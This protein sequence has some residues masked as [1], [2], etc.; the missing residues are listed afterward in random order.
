MT[1]KVVRTLYR[2]LYRL[3]TRFDKNPS[4]KYLIY[5]NVL[6]SDATHSNAESVYYAQLLDT[7]F[8]KSLFMTPFHIGI[9]LRQLLHKEF[10][11][12]SATVSISSRIDAG[13]AAFRKLSAVWRAYQSISAASVDEMTSK[14]P[15][16]AVKI[17]DKIERGVLLCAHP[18]LYGIFSRSVVLIIDHNEKGTYGLILN[19][20]TDMSLENGTRN[21]PRDFLDVFGKH[22]L[23]FGGPLPRLQFI[24]TVSD[25]RGVA[26]PH[27]S[28]NHFVGGGYKK[29]MAAM[30][31]DCAVPHPVIFAGY[32]SWS[33]GQLD[34][35]LQEG[36]WTPVVTDASPLIS[37]MESRAIVPESPKED[38]DFGDSEDSDDSEEGNDMGSSDSEADSDEDDDNQ[39]Y[40]ESMVPVVHEDSAGMWSY[41]MS[42]IATGFSAR[43]HPRDVN[44]WT[45]ESVDWPTL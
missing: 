23:H 19:K 29:V 5:R 28:R 1:S 44:A 21:I 30:Q 39:H 31:G 18:M 10:R 6:P 25:C 34:R 35:E 42:K 45:I 38:L 24:H 41:L 40:D 7:M 37:H 43:K 14:L 20:E 11:S 3:G 36:H 13:F 15:D 17:A 2:S 33:E 32:S 8:G 4:A 16:Q 9:S 12:S 27:C 22:R 26:I